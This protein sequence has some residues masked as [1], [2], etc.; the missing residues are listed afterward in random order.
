MVYCQRTI[1]KSVSFSGVGLHS[2]KQI[3]V[4]LRPALANTGI[5]F[6][7]I[8]L[9]NSPSIQ[10]SAHA[11]ID[12]T[13]ST[14][15]GDKNN[16]CVATI[17]HFMAALFGF[18]IDNIFVDIDNAEMPILDGSSAPFLVLLDEAGIEE[19]NESKKIIVIRKSIEIIDE[20]NPARFIRIEPARKASISYAIDFKSLGK[21]CLTMN[22]TPRDFCQEYSYARTFCQEEDV[23]R[24]YAMGL[25]K[26]GSL[27]NAVVVGKNGQ[28]LNTQGL[29][30]DLECVKHKI[31]DCI[32]DLNLVGKPILGHV[33]AHHAGHDLHTKL[34]KEIL[35]QYQESTAV[36]PQNSQKTKFADFLHTIPKSLLDIEH[37]LITLPI[38]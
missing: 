4:T 24:M 9:P 5:I 6:R 38:G 32:G 26:G 15:I 35:L 8:D 33:I 3:H 17:E 1:K 27:Q 31:L 34:A 22:F 7:R 16:A 14:R 29:R 2:G 10:A 11:V 19:L 21:Q 37:N 18:G 23:L 25:I 13:L 28:V 12:T 30:D 20:K 36:V